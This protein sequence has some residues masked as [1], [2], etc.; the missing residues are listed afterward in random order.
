LLGESLQPALGAVQVFI[1]RT[2]FPADLVV[3]KQIGRAGVFTADKWA[4]EWGSE[5]ST[6]AL[7]RALR[8]VRNFGET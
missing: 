8:T 2:P 6:S 1:K 3:L 7:R 4:D 5:Q